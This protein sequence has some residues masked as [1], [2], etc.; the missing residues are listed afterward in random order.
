MEAEMRVMGVSHAHVGR[1]L[2]TRWQ[3]PDDLVAA[4]GRHHSPSALSRHYAV[5]WCVHV[6][7]W[8]A[9]EAGYGVMPN[10]PATSLQPDVE[11]ELSV[12]PDWRVGLCDMVGRELGKCGDIL[13][14]LTA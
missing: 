6:A 14:L 11:K 13:D 10:I 1:V 12:E 4:V 8:A 9:T 2:L 3:L 7:N 5:T